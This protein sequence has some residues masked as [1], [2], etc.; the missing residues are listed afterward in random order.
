[1]PSWRR[2]STRERGLPQTQASTPANSRRR[3]SILLVERGDTWSSPPEASL[4]DDEL[5][6]GG[7]SPR[8]TETGSNPEHLRDRLR[9]SR[10]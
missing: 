10:R 3:S 9:T 4:D 5:L 2:I 7:Q 1:M 6:L 8:R